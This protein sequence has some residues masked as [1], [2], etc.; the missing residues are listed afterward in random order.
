MLS[1][2]LVT[3]RSQMMQNVSQEGLHMPATTVGSGDNVCAVFGA[4]RCRLH[5]PASLAWHVL[6]RVKLQRAQ[7]LN[8]SE[9]GCR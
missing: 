8:L 9:V 6:T 4:R 5:Q 1:R 2:H 7:A 3:P